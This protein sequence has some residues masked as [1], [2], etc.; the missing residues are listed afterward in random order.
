MTENARDIL[1]EWK[2]GTVFKVPSGYLMVRASDVHALLRELEEDGSGSLLEVMYQRLQDENERLRS[3]ISDDK[4]NFALIG[5]ENS[6]LRQLV[7]E[8]HQAIN[9]LVLLGSVY[10]Q[11]H[12]HKFDSIA[13]SMKRLGFECDGL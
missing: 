1:K 6:D 8:M 13:D 10:K 3:C 12:Q 2:S 5:L 7:C 9:H 4:E 11:Q